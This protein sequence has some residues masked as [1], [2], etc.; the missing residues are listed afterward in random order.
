MEPSTERAEISYHEYRVI[1]HLLRAHVAEHQNR[2]RAMIAF[3]DLI[4]GANAFD[5][6]LLE[7]VR[8]DSKQT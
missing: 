8:D 4:T 1:A 6:D 2:L 5:I 7:V 3:G